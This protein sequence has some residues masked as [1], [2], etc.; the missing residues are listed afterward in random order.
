MYADK[1]K[2]IRS[3]LKLSVAKL[4][5]EINIPARTITSYEQN[6]RTP[7]IE[8]LTQLCIKLNVDPNYFLF[9]K[10]PMFIQNC[11]NTHGFI[12]NEKTILNF[13]SWGKRLSQL[14]AENSETTY[15]FSK[16]TG[17]RE[18]RLEKFI[19]DSIEPS[20]EELNAIKSNVDISIDWLLYG[21]T[22]EKGTQVQDVGLSTYEILKIKQFL[23]DKL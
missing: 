9:G 16:R 7:S 17:I 3:M 4:A 20:I 23:K 21:K 19:M 10:E 14:L 12:K 6:E 22:A 5:D 18:N 11:E 13:K 8:F 1:V 2:K 15:A